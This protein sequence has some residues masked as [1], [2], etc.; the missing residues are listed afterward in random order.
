MTR[1]NP[2]YCKI[3]CQIKVLI[4]LRPSASKPHVKSIKCKTISVQLIFICS[5]WATECP[6][7]C[8]SV[9][10]PQPRGERRTPERR[11]GT[12]TTQAKSLAWRQKLESREA[13]I[14]THKS[15]A[16][17]GRTGGHRHTWGRITQPGPLAIA[18][19]TAT[20]PPNNP[21]CAAE[22]PEL[23]PT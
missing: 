3:S 20:T 9:R 1:Q 8:P 23:C 2:F 15:T 5:P 16:L 6:R 14:H 10:T 12:K 19:R 21:G 13:G 18:Q 4:S 22:T 17:A 7:T 11:K